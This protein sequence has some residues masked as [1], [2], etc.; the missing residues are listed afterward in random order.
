MPTDLASNSGS[1]AQKKDQAE[2]KKIDKLN[3]IRCL[4]LLPFKGCHYENE[5]TNHRLISVTASALCQALFYR[6][7]HH[8]V[9][10][11]GRY[12]YCLRFEETKFQTRLRHVF[13]GDS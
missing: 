6:L 10:G 3:Y 1:K 12:T 2:K 11:W 13:E 9:M 4:K 5:E 7:N 8:N